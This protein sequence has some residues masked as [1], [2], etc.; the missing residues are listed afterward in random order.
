MTI[1]TIQFYWRIRIRFNY[2]ILF[3]PRN[4]LCTCSKSRDF[5]AEVSVLPSS[6]VLVAGKRFTNSG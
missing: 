5:A 3:V 2:M 6:T 4:R 1:G